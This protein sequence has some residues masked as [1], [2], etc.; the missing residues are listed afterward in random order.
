MELLK[1][2]VLHNDGRTVDIRSIKLT[3]GH[4][5]KE[6]V[7][8]PLKVQYGKQDV[9]IELGEYI[10]LIKKMLQLVLYA[11]AVNADVQKADPGRKVVRPKSIGDIKDKYKEISRWDVGNNIVKKIRNYKKVHPAVSSETDKKESSDQTIHQSEHCHITPHV[12]KG[13]WQ[14]YWI[15]KK[16]G[17]EERKLVLRWKHFI[18]VNASEPDALPITINCIKDDKSFPT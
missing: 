8:E 6:C 5:L 9:D 11:C 1:F 17:S 2:L 13:H 15:G 4:T 16:D 14:S 7:A 10:S 3:T 12:R 18:Y